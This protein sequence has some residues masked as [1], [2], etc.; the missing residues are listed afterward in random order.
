M[1]GSGLVQEQELTVLAQ[2]LSVLH[3]ATDGVLQPHLLQLGP[4][5]LG[6]RSGQRHGYSPH[7]VGLLC[8]QLP[9]VR[10]SA[11]GVEEFRDVIRSPLSFVGLFLFT[12]G[13]GGGLKWGLGFKGKT[14]G[15][16]TSV[17]S[18]E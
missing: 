1:R 7:R 14:E 8:R 10:L 12:C 16:P 13:K 3:E 15:S 17:T 2:I 18:A 9:G 6:R 11:N 4:Q 5:V